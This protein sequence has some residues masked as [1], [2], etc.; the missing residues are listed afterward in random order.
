MGMGNSKNC[1]A[2]ATADSM[3]MPVSR[4]AVPGFEVNLVVFEFAVIFLTPFDRGQKRNPGT[5][6][7]GAIWFDKTNGGAALRRTFPLIRTYKGI[8]C[9]PSVPEFHRLG[10]LPGSQT[11][12]AGRDLHPAPK[13][14]CHLLLY[15]SPA[16][17][18]GAGL[19]RGVK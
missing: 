7:T 16:V 15:A 12:T 14:I 19:T 13:S 4:R 10:P 3:A 5:W 11:F 18:Q 6:R 17:C 8:P 1:S 9:S 2:K